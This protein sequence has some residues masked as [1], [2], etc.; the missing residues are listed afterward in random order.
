MD[1]F[2]IIGIFL[3]SSFIQGITGFGFSLIAIPLLLS[4][5]GPKTLIIY[6]VTY[7]LFINV[8]IVRNYYRDAN[9]KRIMPLLISAII[10]TFVGV[11]YLKNIDERMLKLIIGSLLILVGIIN[12]FGIKFSFKN[13]NKIFLP[14]GAISGVLNGI[15]G[16]SGPP[17]LM[18]ISNLD[19]EIS[20]FKATLS[21][22]F[23]TLNVVT[24]ISYI[25]NGLY[26]I[27]DI[28]IM[29]TYLPGIIL[30]VFLGIIISKQISKLVFKR[31]VDISILLMGMNIFLQV[32]HR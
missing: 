31:I 8:I 12:N 29:A 22:Y 27:K 17:V 21:T 24:I 7:S 19:M 20:E 11:H 16:I 26:S 18:F 2:Y 15:G 1:R 4:F 30:G 25:Y 13:P 10:F 6:T 32:I 28:K 3:F 5:I 23:L 9:L 14:V